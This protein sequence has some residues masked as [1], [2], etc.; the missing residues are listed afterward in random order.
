MIINMSKNEELKELTIKPEGRLDS[1][2]SDEFFD[3]VNESFTEDF[4]KLIID[5]NCIDFIS[6]KGLRVLVSIY[7]SLNGRTMEATGAN[8][9]VM[10]ILR[11]SGLLKVI[12]VK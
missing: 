7:K 1:T 12:E 6:S 11:L 2:C 3:Y 10:E 4:N 8:V 9:S 5:F